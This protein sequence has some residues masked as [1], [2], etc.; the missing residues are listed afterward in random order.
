MI[1]FP[2]KIEK[3]NSFLSVGKLLILFII[4]A[5]VLVACGGE[6]PTSGLSPT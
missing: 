5:L 4:V 6:D 2:S 1:G 3:N